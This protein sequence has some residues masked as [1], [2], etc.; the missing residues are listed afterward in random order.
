MS[1]FST[2]REAKEFLIARIVAEA[3]RE[4]IPL[5]EVERKMLYFS[6]T[7][8]TLPDIMEVNDEFD[9]QYNQN[10][11]EKKIARLIHKDAVRLRKENPH[12]FATW[13]SAVR[14]LSKED[15]YLSVMI[16]R[17]SVGRSGISDNWKTIAILVVG[18][19]LLI[20]L[21][22]LYGYL[23]LAGTSRDGQINGSYAI[24]ERNN[25]MF[26]SIVGYLW[27]SAV[28]LYLCGTIYAHFDPKRRL[29][30]SV[31]RFIQKLVGRDEPH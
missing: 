24:D 2:A 6:E 5:S 12:E 28:I 21:E 20:G 17:A 14:K 18:G 22:L 31:D 19:A 3:G 27:L 26:G 1:T 8:W 30:S 25:K 23:G 13:N 11:Y 15:H 9:R 29:Y 4:N 10:D 16:E 7:G